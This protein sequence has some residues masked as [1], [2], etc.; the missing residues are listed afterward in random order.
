MLT[1]YQNNYLLTTKIIDGTEVDYLHT[2]EDI[3]IP[4][5]IR[6]D[7][8]KFVFKD[9]TGNIIH[10]KGEFEFQLTI[11]YRVEC[12]CKDTPTL[13]STNQFSMIEV[14]SNN[15]FPFTL[16]HIFCFSIDI[17]Y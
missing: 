3:C 14:L 15:F 11:E 4:M 12:E 6:F 13:I 1:A 17:S 10:L 16:S 8:F 9:L 2:V 5:I 7:R